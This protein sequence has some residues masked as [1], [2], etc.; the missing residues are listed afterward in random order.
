MKTRTRI[1]TACP[2]AQL[3]YSTSH[4]KELT[5]TVEVYTAANAAKLFDTIFGRPSERVKVVN[6]MYS[7]KPS[8]EYMKYSSRFKK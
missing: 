8:Q 7:Y 3:V 6:G 5:S 4:Y 2:N 1:R